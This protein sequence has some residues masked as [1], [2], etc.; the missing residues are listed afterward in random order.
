MRLF[1][2][3]KK[4]GSVLHNVAAI[5]VCSADIAKKFT[6]KPINVADYASSSNTQRYLFC[7]HQMNVDVK[8]AL[9]NNRTDLDNLDIMIRTFMHFLFLSFFSYCQ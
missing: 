8:D 3:P 6:E 4:N 5:I 1:I 9:I 7:F 2:I